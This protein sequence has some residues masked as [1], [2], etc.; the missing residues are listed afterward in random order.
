MIK[1]YWLIWVVLELFWCLVPVSEN[2]CFN[3]IRHKNVNIFFCV[4]CFQYDTANRFSINNIL[5]CH[6][7]IS[8]YL[9]EMWRTIWP[10]ITVKLSIASVH[11]FGL[12]VWVTRPVVWLTLQKLRSF[13]SSLSK[14]FD[15]APN[16]GSPYIPHWLFMYINLILILEDNYLRQWRRQISA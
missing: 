7:S 3:I 10:H 1:E 8:V 2:L 4:A 14:A 6:G 13:K 11:Q 9:W 5:L 15:K 12:V 16:W